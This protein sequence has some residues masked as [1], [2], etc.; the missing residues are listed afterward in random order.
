MLAGAAVAAGVAGFGAAGA[1]GP[2]GAGVLADDAG[3]DGAEGGGGEGGEDGR[4][5]GDGFGDAFAAGQAGADELVGVAAV[6]FG[7]GRAGRGAAVAAGFVD[8][9]VG[10][11]EG[12][13]RA[14]Q[15][16]GARVDDPQICR[17]GGWG[18]CIRRQTRC[19]RASRSSRLRPGRARRLR[20]MA[21]MP[22]GGEGGH[23]ASTTLAGE[24]GGLG[25]ARL[26]E[27]GAH[28]GVPLVGV[29]GAVGAVDVPG[30]AAGQWGVAAG[31]VGPGHRVGGDQQVAGLDEASDFEPEA[32]QPG[33]AAFVQDGDEGVDLGGGLAAADRAEADQGLGGQ[34]DPGVLVA[35][36]AAQVVGDRPALQDR[37]DRQAG[38]QVAEGQ[39]VGD[40]AALM[41]GDG[42]PGA[43][44]DERF[45]H[46]VLGGGPGQVADLVAVA[47]DP[48]GVLAG[49]GA[50]VPGAV[51]RQFGEATGIQRPRAGG[52]RGGACSRAG[53]GR[54]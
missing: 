32:V 50:V 5:G 42:Q 53:G 33:D 12:G 9:P 41:L 19:D 44:G 24:Q 40:G 8:H 36:G 39:E 23:Q 34:V 35:V 27:C 2:V 49:G 47:A 28:V 15:F 11:A 30:F 21:R 54:R 14:Q 31:G 29:A 16:A 46:P 3:V 25:V 17:T 10:H 4:V 7:A 18:G 52:A 26:G 51:G 22:G 45:A 43:G 1:A 20:P 6:G 48:G 37:D 13:H 38:V